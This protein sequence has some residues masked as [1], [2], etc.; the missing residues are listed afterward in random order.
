MGLGVQADPLEPKVPPKVDRVLAV[1]AWQM[2]DV[3]PRIVGGPHDQVGL[4]GVSR[5][6]RWVSGIFA[7][8]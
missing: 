8:A 3:R 2:A 5:R 6:V 4:R 1:G 7:Y